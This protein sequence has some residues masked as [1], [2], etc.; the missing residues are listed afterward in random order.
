MGS[1]SFPP[2]V[3]DLMI[4]RSADAPDFDG[5]LPAGITAAIQN[6]G[7]SFDPSKP[8]IG[9]DVWL[10]VDG[11]SGPNPILGGQRP[12]DSTVLFA[13]DVVISGTLYSE[14][15]VMEVITHTSNQYEGDM[16]LSGNLFAREINETLL[17]PGS[18]QWVDFQAEAGN[19]ILVIDSTNERVGIGTPDPDEA[20]HISDELTGAKARLAIT[21]HNTANW[22]DGPDVIFQRNDGTTAATEGVDHGDR[23]GSIYWQGI[24]ANGQTI[25]DAKSSAAISVNIVGTPSA[26]SVPMAI[27]LRTAGYSTNTGNP[28]WRLGVGPSGMVQIGGMPHTQYPLVN[29]AQDGGGASGQLDIRWSD[30]DGNPANAIFDPTDTDLVGAGPLVIWG[31][32]EFTGAA[33]DKKNLVIGTDG[34]VQWGPATIGPACEVDAC[35]GS[36]DDTYE[37]G[38]W[39][40][41]NDTLVG[42][43][44][45]RLNEVLGMMAPQPCP[46]ANNLG[47]PALDTNASPQ[48][49]N[50]KLS[51][52]QQSNWTNETVDGTATL[53]PSPGMFPALGAIGDLFGANVQISYTD[54]EDTR[55]ATGPTIAEE[56]TRLGVFYGNGTIGPRLMLDINFD[57]GPDPVSGPPFNYPLGAFGQGSVGDIYLVVNGAIAAIITDSSM[58]NNDAAITNIG[59][60]N[61]KI[62][63][64]PLAPAHFDNGEDLCTYFHREYGRVEIDPQDMAIGWNWA[65]IEHMTE[66]GG[67]GAPGIVYSSYVTWL[68]DDQTVEPSFNPQAVTMNSVAG[69]VTLSGVK[70]LKTADVNYV[71]DVNN[72]YT[73]FY[74]SGNAAQQW[75]DNTTDNPPGLV[76]PINEILKVPDGSAGDHTGIGIATVINVD[77]DIPL[78]T[79]VCAT[80]NTWRLGNSVGLVGTVKHPFDN[81]DINGNSTWGLGTWI[82]LEDASIGTIADTWLMYDHNKSSIASLS[83]GCD[84]KE[85][86]NFLTEEFR[87]LGDGADS[88]GSNNAYEL[89]TDITSGM[90]PWDKE[91]T[92]SDS[93]G[94][95]SAGYMGLMCY[96]GSL[97]SPK[98]T[99]GTGV[100][101]GDFTNITNPSPADVSAL[102]PAVTEGPQR[103]YDQ[104]ILAGERYFYRLFENTG[105]ADDAIWTVNISTVDTSG[106]TTIVD[107]DDTLTSDTISIEIRVPGDGTNTG[108]FQGTG[109]LD[110]SVVK[111]GSYGHGDG[112]L[113]TAGVHTIG[114]GTPASFICDLGSGRKVKQNDYIV[115]RIKARG[116]FANTLNRVMVAW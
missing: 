106:T 47:S 4:Y 35:D 104:T 84:N 17:A 87:A 36:P 88:G 98:N 46:L 108:V 102:W 59:S 56:D 112:I 24:D 79:P 28:D 73:E 42:C 43:A 11:A 27:G 48:W 26:G 51:E 21:Q 9:T 18:R 55:G 109:W 81:D 20:L 113:Q 77:K 57:D 22:A 85:I 82:P 71:Y 38:L 45:D 7:A 40:F 14:R 2:N 70:Y 65:R 8:S 32:R 52:V 30:V 100:T 66:I 80:P 29:S 34:V 78:V 116:D 94:G 76:P 39:P 107:R 91:K 72:A 62:H 63:V 69:P 97:R 41:T 92:L 114:L 58:A 6:V 103:N 74:R 33:A 49:Q 99:S 53:S 86:E 31:L 83:V 50:A 75:S 115:M 90:T 19:S 111:G 37:D 13:G 16:I 95:A 93:G 89:Q 60:N 3:P 68:I 110:C 5:D 96:N 15:Q 61:S 1:G 105:A 54:P 64:G 67:G 25:Q 101:N 44:I 12:P 10:Y 23:I